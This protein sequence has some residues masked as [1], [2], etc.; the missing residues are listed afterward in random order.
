MAAVATIPLITTTQNEISYPTYI[1][2][3]LGSCKV[4][5]YSDLIIRQVCDV[6]RTS[7]CR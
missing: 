4:L 1:A 6:R 5:R 2:Q 3:P 7:Y